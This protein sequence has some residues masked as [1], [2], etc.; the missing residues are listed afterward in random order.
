MS[1]EA[2]L[3]QLETFSSALKDTNQVLQ[4]ISTQQDEQYAVIDQLLQ[5]K[6][7]IIDTIYTLN[8]LLQT[9]DY[10]FR[11]PN[12]GGNLGARHRPRYNYCFEVMRVD[13]NKNRNWNRKRQTVAGYKKTYRGKESQVNRG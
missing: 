2:I 4:S 1:Y 5:T 11:L 6:N 12:R 10:Y 7:D 3:E 9:C 13:N 8:K